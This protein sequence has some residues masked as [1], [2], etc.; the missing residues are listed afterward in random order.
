MVGLYLLVALVLP[1]RESLA[2]EE[3]VDAIAAQVG[4]EIVLVSDVDQISAELEKQ[5]RS[6]GVSNNDVLMMRAEALERLIEAKL[7][8]RVVKQTEMEATDEEI[9]RAITQIAKENNLTLQQLARGVTSHGISFE[10][11]REKIKDEIDRAKI[12]NSM[13]R[14]R[15]AVEPEEVQKLFLERHGDQPVGGEQVHLR[16]IL[17]P[18]G[19]SVMRSHE[20]ACPEVEKARKEI[21]SGQKSFET[22]ARKISVLKAESGG[23]VGWLHADD[24]AAWMKPAITGLSPGEVSAVIPT[25][26]GC[27]LLMVVERKS[28]APTT[29]QD[30]TPELER[31]IF[32]RKTNEEYIRWVDRLRDQT[33][34][35]RKGLFAE[36]TRLL[37]ENATS[38]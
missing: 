27:N 22:V 8:R 37:R 5:M 30:A 25:N 33:Y 16:H 31:E 13:I 14:S 1:H 20:A 24:I 3:I 2:V 4:N 10:V 17:V 35:Q 12:V 7:L 18:A 6:S 23:D 19:V 26:F 28:Y 9:D 36:T 32:D 34:I 15:I 11:Y 29:L 38:P 21:V